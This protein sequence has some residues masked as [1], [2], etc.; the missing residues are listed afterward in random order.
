VPALKRVGVLEQ[1]RRALVEGVE[2]GGFAL[3]VGGLVE[4][5]AHGD[6]HPEELRRLEAL[7]GLLGFVDDEVAI[8]EGLDA[9]EVELEVGGRIEGGGE[10]GE[11][12]VEE[13]GV[14]ALDGDAVLEV[15]LERAAGGRPSGRR[16]RRA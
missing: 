8:V 4:G 3:A 5:E 2:A 9:E 7:R 13:A 14:E 16:C 10:L 12:E 1:K 15:F 6:A 11:I